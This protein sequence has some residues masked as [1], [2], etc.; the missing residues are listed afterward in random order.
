VHWQL[1]AGCSGREIEAGGKKFTTP[2][3]TLGAATSGRASM[4]WFTMWRAWH[5]SCPGTDLD[6]ERQL[7]CSL[8]LP[9]A[10]GV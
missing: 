4:S 5:Y 2:C 10:A 7:G 3:S 1:H 8:A 6:R 9:P